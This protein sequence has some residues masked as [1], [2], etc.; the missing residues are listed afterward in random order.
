MSAAFVALLRAAGVSRP[1]LARATGRTRSAVDRW[2][3]GTAQP[4]AEVLAWL[5][6]RLQDPPPRLPKRRGQPKAEEAATE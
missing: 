5:Y 1:W 4:P 6:R 3:N 2:C